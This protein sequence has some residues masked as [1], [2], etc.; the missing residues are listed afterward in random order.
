MKSVAILVV[1]RNARNCNALLS[2]LGGSVSPPP[3]EIVIAWN[4]TSEEKSRIQ[5]HRDLQVKIVDHTP[6]H[7]A[8][9]N[10]FLA[11]RVS[12]EV[13]GFV[14]DDIVAD[15]GAM[16]AVAECFRHPGIGIAGG[17]LRYPSG[18]LQHAGVFFREDG[19]PYHLDK[20][21]GA[22]DFDKH[23]FSRFVPAVTGAF[24]FI[25][26]DEF[27]KLEFD[28][29]YDVAGE[30]IDLCLRY[31]EKFPREIYYCAGASAVHVEND[32]RKEFDQRLTPPESLAKLRAVATR[33]GP[34]GKLSEPRRF[35][36]TIFTEKPGWILHR[37]AQEIQE[38]LKYCD[39]R[40]NG[41]VAGTDIAYYV[42]YGYF[43]K[44]SGNELI[45]ANFTHF[46][47]D[48]LA[49]KFVETARIADLCTAVSRSTANKLAQLGVPMR[50]IR[51]IEV[52]ADASFRPRAV[53]GIVGRTYPGS[54]KGEDLVVKLAADAEIAKVAKLVATNEG[55]NLPVWEFEDRR[56]FYSA[57]D[58]L[59][60][61]SRKEG[62]PVPFM[63]AL[64]CGKLSVAPAIGVIPDYP[65]IEYEAGNYDD[66]RK[67]MLQ[68]ANQIVERKNVYAKSMRGNNWDSWAHAHELAFRDLL[69]AKQLDEK[70]P[71]Q[72]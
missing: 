37:K 53:F 49:E 45:C 31:R 26:R 60:V 38:R 64:A 28:P 12:S 8:K 44:K 22:E 48:H 71:E 39:V 46:D 57:I 18:K 23:S 47:E 29:S 62:G 4:G 17:Q 43:R 69:A 65:H 52:G 68:V 67:V 72:D 16:Q 27:A 55:W 10:N 30:D 14:N 2:S 19:T 54:R 34:A 63:E 1:S 32:T 35:K 3:M 42:N 13:L 66:L 25:R 11:T 21:A 36:V 7:F 41:D 50:R 15:P 58:V 70:L 59:L 5:P 20:G 6:Y 51:V 9:N 61:P 40:I 56:D 33:T 24:L